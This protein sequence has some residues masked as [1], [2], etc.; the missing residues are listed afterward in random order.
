MDALS[1]GIP[2]ELLLLVYGPHLHH[3]W[4]LL[5]H[6]CIHFFVAENF[7]SSKNSN[8]DPNLIFD[9]LSIGILSRL[10]L[11]VCHLYLHRFRYLLVHFCIHFFVPKIFIF[12]HETQF[13]SLPYF[14][15]I[16]PFKCLSR[17]FSESVAHSSIIFYSFFF[18]FCSIF[19]SK[20]NLFCLKL[21]FLLKQIFLCFSY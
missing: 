3:F 16:F 1:I 18:I 15:K 19:S 11:R 13:F 12:H 21:F 7:F 14:L 6:F 17:I 9:A 5:V 8:F 20:K 4:Y 10:L 2:P